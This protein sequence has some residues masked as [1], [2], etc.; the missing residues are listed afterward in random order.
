RG[1]W[2]G[3]QLDL[4]LTAALGIGSVTVV[5]G[6]IRKQC[7]DPVFFDI[8][9]IRLKEVR[10][11]VV[12]SRG[13]F[14]AGFDDLFPS[15]R[16]LEVDTPGLTTPVLSRLPFRNLQRPVY[17]MDPDTRWTPPDRPISIQ[18]AM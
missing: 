4:G 8:A 6:S 1:L 9:G 2:A 16:V 12:K 18:P 3:R 7:A 13:H 10:T 15:E 14:R 11:L 17:P 5:V